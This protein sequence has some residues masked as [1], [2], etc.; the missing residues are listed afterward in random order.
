MHLGAYNVQIL[1]KKWRL[2]AIISIIMS[3]P[4]QLM[5]IQQLRKRVQMDLEIRYIDRDYNSAN[6]L[7]WKAL[8]AEDVDYL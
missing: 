4:E 5:P 6:A 3:V 2:G 1:L 7:C 8:F